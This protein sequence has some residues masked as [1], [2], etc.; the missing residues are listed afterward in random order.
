MQSW[1]NN[2][3]MARAREFLRR[4]WRRAL[5]LREKLALKEEAFHLVLAGVVGV[6]G[7]LVNLF[8]YY[9]VHLVQ[10]GAPVEVAERLPD[11]ERVLVPTLGGLAAGLWAA[12]AAGGGGDGVNR[13]VAAELTGT[14]GSGAGGGFFAMPEVGDE[15]LVAFAAMA[16]A[17]TRPFCGASQ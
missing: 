1:L 12:V 5:Q 14:T 8:F 11:W 4:H 16:R 7:G 2:G 6:I 13:V 15:V 10:P 3:L 9:A 17:M